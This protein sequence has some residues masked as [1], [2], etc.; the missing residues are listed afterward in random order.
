MKKSPF[1]SA[2]FCN[3]SGH[4]IFTSFVRFIWY[5]RAFDIM[6]KDEFFSPIIYC[7]GDIVAVQC[8]VRFCCTV[9]WVH[10]TYTYISLP[11]GPPSCLGHRKAW[12]RAPC[13][14]C[15]RFPAITQIRI[16]ILVS[17]LTSPTSVLIHLLSV[18]VSLFLPADRSIYTVSLDSTHAGD[19]SLWFS[20][21][22]S[23]IIT[24]VEDPFSCLL[25]ATNVFFG[26]MA[27]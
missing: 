26:E 19:T 11:S 27:V 1:I 2:V 15:T 3:F 18:S 13:A 24:D 20:A 10:C 25:A 14:V 7:F 12:S 22:I 17:C 9:R 8:C 6:M 5:F 23:L 21:C 16:S 4:K